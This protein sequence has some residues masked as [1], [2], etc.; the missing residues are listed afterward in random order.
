MDGFGHK[1]RMLHER[2]STKLSEGSEAEA[3]MDAPS[4]KISEMRPSKYDTKQKVIRVWEEFR[5]KCLFSPPEKT[6][7]QWQMV[8]AQ[9]IYEV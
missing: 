2:Y 3:G 7:K 5:E 1:A 8:I 4:R 6:A 9:T